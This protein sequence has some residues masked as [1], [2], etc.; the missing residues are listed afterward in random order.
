MQPYKHNT[1]YFKD[2]DN[3]EKAYW[4][5]FLYADGS[6]VR[7]YNK[8]NEVRTYSL[9]LGLARKDED[10]I[11]KF[12]EAIESE[13]PVLERST[14]LKKTNKEYK[15]SRMTI[16]N[17]DIC[18]S[19]IEKGCVPDKASSIRFPNTNI[20][21]EEF[22]VDFIRGYF[23]GDGGVYYYEYPAPKDKPNRNPTK[24]FKSSFV[25]NKTMMLSIKSWLEQNNIKTGKLHSLKN[26]EEFSQFFIFGHKNLLNFYKTLKFENRISLNRKRKKFQK[27]FKHL[28]LQ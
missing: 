7:F 21:P 19:L 6:I 26:S 4:L 27:V 3:S 24:V 28:N 10:H 25:G 15:S 8:N 13:A 9:E 11:Y 1:E 16:Y 5:G 17:K 18:L 12:K 20:L 22:Q 14:F 2:I 23:D